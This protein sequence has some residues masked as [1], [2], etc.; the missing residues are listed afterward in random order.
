MHTCAQVDV[1]RQC[2][3]HSC[4][5]VPVCWNANGGLGGL[6]EPGR[7]HVTFLCASS[8]ASIGLGQLRVY[9]VAR[10]KV[11]VQGAPDPAALSLV[12]FTKSA[13]SPQWN[14][15]H[16]NIKPE[17]CDIMC[18]QINPSQDAAL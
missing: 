12:D 2:T 14:I 3:Q 9:I 13:C 17:T 15:E 1:V 6:Q 5:C 8:S 4:I 10:V 11:K 18:V 7:C 16:S